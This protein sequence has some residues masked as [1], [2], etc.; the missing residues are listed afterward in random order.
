MFE[1]TSI[2]GPPIFG[3]F[4]RGSGVA[5]GSLASWRLSMAA[6]CW[7]SGRSKHAVMAVDSCWTLAKRMD[8]KPIPVKPWEVR[9]VVNG[10]LMVPGLGPLWI[11]KTL[12]PRAVCHTW[13]DSGRAS[14]PHSA[15]PLSI[16]KNHFVQTHSQCIWHNTY[17]THVVYPPI[18]MCIFVLLYT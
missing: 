6:F 12:V 3:A 9:P 5:L 14:P 8:F 15:S 16:D 10:F 13:V 2:N 7:I 18:H 11:V 17:V 1:T 4:A